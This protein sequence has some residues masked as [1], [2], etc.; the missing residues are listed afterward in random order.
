MS[1]SAPQ[2]GSKM[3]ELHIQSATQAESR[4]RVSPTPVSLHMEGDMPFLASLLSH[5]A[6]DMTKSTSTE[7]VHSTVHAYKP[8]IE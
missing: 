7:G 8:F 3:E 2:T 1:P 6:V 5:N 4:K